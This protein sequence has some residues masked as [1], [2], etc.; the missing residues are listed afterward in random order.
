MADINPH[1][2]WWVIAA[3]AVIPGAVTIYQLIR[4]SR[5]KAEDRQVA[6]RSGVVARV[7][8]QTKTLLDRLSADVLQLRQRLDG[9]E[10]ELTYARTNAWRWHD[11][12]QHMRQHAYDARALVPPG[13][14][15]P[16]G[17]PPLELPA[18]D[19]ENKI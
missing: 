1:D 7:D 13:R 8:A 14:L 4:N 10:E 12:A 5:D 16:A 11:L 18:F 9:V 3:G 17:W 2:P 15:P 19:I 6:E